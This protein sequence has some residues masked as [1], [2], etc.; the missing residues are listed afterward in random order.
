MKI[1][2]LTICLGED[3]Q[4]K[5]GSAGISKEIYAKRNGYDFIYIKETM[6]ATRKPHWTKIKALQYFI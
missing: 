6:D 1:A 2:V 3:Y 4:K 5:W